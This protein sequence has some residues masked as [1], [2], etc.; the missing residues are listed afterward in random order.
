MSTEPVACKGHLSAH[1]WG[2][3]VKGGHEKPLQGCHLTL[4]CG[5]RP[6]GHYRPPIS[7]FPVQQG[8]ILTYL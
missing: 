8:A 4:G 1:L 3:G 7:G 2:T 6:S 5:L